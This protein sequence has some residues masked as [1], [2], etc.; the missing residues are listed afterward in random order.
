MVH[1]IDHP[2]VAHKLTLMRKKDTSTKTFRALMEEIG[3]LFAYELTR[4]LPLVQEDIE[5][6]L[7]RMKSP[8]LEG[9]KIVLVAILRAGMGLADGM[10]HILPSA[11]IGHLGI[12]RDLKTHVAIEYYCKLPDRMSERHAI[13]LGPM[14]AT[15]NTAAA[16]VDRVLQTGA[17]SVRYACLVA[18]REG[19]VS[20]EEH[21]PEVPLYTAAIDDGLNENGFIVPGMGDAGDRMFGTK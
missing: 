19:V 18:S 3:M 21:H 6:P 13:V 2:L 16:A 17:L 4:D 7:S 20:F 8:V 12:Y 10:L 9:K 5:T 14:M 15:G 1:V 11:R